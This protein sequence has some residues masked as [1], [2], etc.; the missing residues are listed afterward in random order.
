MPP[1]R[2]PKWACLHPHVSILWCSPTCLHRHT[3]APWMLAVTV[4][5]RVEAGCG[6]V[7]RESFQKVAIREEP[8]ER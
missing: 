4:A 3:H 1:R 2:P 7:F 8:P 6:G 5:G